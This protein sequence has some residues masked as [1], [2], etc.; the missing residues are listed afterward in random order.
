MVGQTDDLNNY[1][2]NLPGMQPE[3]VY[4]F[5]ANQTGTVDV[6]L[7]CDDANGDDYD[8][9]ILEDTCNSGT[10]IDVSYNV[11]DDSITVS[12]VAGHTY[13]IVIEAYSGTGVFNLEINCSWSI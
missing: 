2:C 3:R 6:L 11:G 1:A 8:L 10:C 9:L 5:T 4:S 13:F 12:T 7:D